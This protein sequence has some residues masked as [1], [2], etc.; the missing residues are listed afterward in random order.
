[1]IGNRQKKDTNKASGPQS[2]KNAIQILSEDSG[3]LSVVAS[4]FEERD[5]W[6]HDLEELVNGYYLR[7]GK[8]VVEVDEQDL[9]LFLKAKLRF[10]FQK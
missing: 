1:M 10:C 3:M 9:K 4:T 2:I 8:L 5:V 6:R 7:R